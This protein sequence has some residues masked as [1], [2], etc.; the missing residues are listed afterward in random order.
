VLDPVHVLKDRLRSI[1]LRFRAG[2]TPAPPPV[3]RIALDYYV[4]SAPHPQNALDL[5]Q[6][7]WSSAL[8]GEHASLRAGTAGL[9][10]DPRLEWAAAQLGGFGGRTV[11][12]L[13]PLEGGHTF[14]I[15]KGGAARVTAVEANARAY[16]KCLIVKE[17][18]G[19][20]RSHFLCGD[21][22]QYLRTDPT[23]FD[24]CVA[25][26]V[27]YHVR[28]PV[29]LI[30]RLA[31]R[32]DR[33][34]VWTHYYDPHLVARNGSVADRFNGVEQAEFAGFRCTVRRFEYR[35]AL[36]WNGFCGGSEACGCWMTRDDLLACLKWFGFDVVQ[37]CFEEP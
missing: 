1:W 9:F 23:R 22:M 6:G 14:M 37:V 8:P 32:T 13:G 5:F 19:L 4:R 10:E 3:P 18:L 7:E 17:L 30:A 33:L 21:L 15:E 2:E 26:G 31:E 35:H 12:E 20:V 36:E 28:N 24:A 25:S 34:F 29:E 11:L 27:L 16:L